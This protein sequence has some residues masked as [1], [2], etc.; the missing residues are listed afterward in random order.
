MRRLFPLALGFLLGCD[1]L[2]RAPLRPPA[3]ESCDPADAYLN[4]DRDPALAKNTLPPGAHYSILPGVSLSHPVASRLTQIDDAFH[5]RSSKH[6]LVVSGTRDPARQARAMIRVIEL[7]GSLIK[8]YEDRE[9]AS[10]IQRAYDRARASKKKHEEVVS[11]VQSTLQAQIQRGVYI[12]AHLRAGAVD[13]RNTIMTE[14]DK[15]AFRAAV[16]EVGG[17]S[18]LEEHRPPHFHLEIDREKEKEKERERERDRD[19]EP[20]PPSR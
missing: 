3:P 18:L 2:E 19:R 4:E 16:R 1:V 10:E 15:K 17:V 12:S 11:A 9:A 6:I 5:R 20:D 7:G 8:L 14:A 13:V